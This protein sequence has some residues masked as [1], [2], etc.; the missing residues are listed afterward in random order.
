MIVQRTIPPLAWALLFLLA[1]MWGGSFLANRIALEEVGV[2]TT[3]AF[4][5]AGASVVLWG[6]V[7]LRGLRAPLTPRSIGTFLVLG[8]LNNAVPFTL[9]VWGQQH[10]ASGLAAI[11][12]ASTAIFT[13]LLVALIFSDERLTKHKAVGVTL[14]F[15]GVITAIGI[16]NLTKLDLRSVSQ[17]ALMGSSLSY[18]ISAAIGRVYLKGIRPEVSAAGMLTSAALFMVPMAIWL[19]GVPT[20]G[21]HAATFGALA[22]LAVIS[23]A[24]AY[25]LYYVVLNLAGAGNLSLVTL[26]V[27]PVAIV[28]GAVVYGETLAANAFLGFA[29]LALGLLIIDGRLGTR[30]KPR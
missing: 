27:A 7:I 2:F 21:Y 30:K 20:F 15:A 14:G 12:N 28:L 3:V 24:F 13:V 23:S 11:L 26:L 19:E 5:V 18:A 22:Y 16:E 17:L 1:F 9:I 29:L 25:M 10:I 4:R 8:L 6:Y